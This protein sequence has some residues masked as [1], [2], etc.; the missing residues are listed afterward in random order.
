MRTDHLLPPGFL[1][2]AL[3]AD[4]LAGLNAA[5]KW[6]PPKWFYDAHG[7]ALFEK[8]TELPQ[9]YPARG[10]GDPAGGG[11]GDR[12]PHRRV[13]AAG[14]WSAPVVGAVH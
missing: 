2:R 7:S 9:Y 8:I 12:R 11:A 3:H 6:L 1:A 5:P 10:T 4:A 14:T 13:C